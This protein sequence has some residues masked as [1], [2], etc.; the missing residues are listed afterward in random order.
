MKEYIF[1]YGTL[2]KEKTQLELFGRILQ[3]SADTLKGYKAYAIKI[4]DAK[5]L[6]KG[7][8]KNQLT[9]IISEDNNDC[10]KGT[11]LEVTED[12]LL[13]A[14]RYEPDGYKRIKIVLESGKDAWIY[15]AI[16]FINSNGK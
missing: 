10:I 8:Q 11:A 12:E 15:S 1:S 4:T 13:M 6:A 7:E 5:F 9:A 14:D 16:E 3:G 2:Q